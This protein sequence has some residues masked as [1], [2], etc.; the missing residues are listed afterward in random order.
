MSYSSNLSFAERASGEEDDLLVPNPN[1]LP[2]ADDSEEDVETSEA[3]ESEEED[4]VETEHNAGGKV[5]LTNEDIL[6]AL[7]LKGYKRTDRIAYEFER[8]N[9]VFVSFEKRRA[10]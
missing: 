2:Q 7:T 5:P 4:E 3:E 10:H 6:H 9:L 8:Y 1:H